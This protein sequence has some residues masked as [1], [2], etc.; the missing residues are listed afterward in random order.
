MS[1]EAPKNE[2][3]KIQSLRS[4]LNSEQ[5][6]NEIVKALPEICT[7]DRFMRVL[8]TTLTKNPKL[9]ECDRNSLL[10]ALLDC[11]QLGIEPDGRRAHLIPYGQNIQLIIDYKGLVELAMRSGKISNIHA[12]EVCENDEFV[13]NKGKI[14]K[15]IPNWKDRG[16]PYLVYAN[17]IFKDGCE[18][19]EVMTLE[20][21]NKVKAC[22][23]SANSTSSPWNTFPSEMR[24]KTVFRRLSKWLPLS[25]EDMNIIEKTEKLEYDFDMP[26][27]KK[28]IKVPLNLEPEKASFEPE[29]TN[30]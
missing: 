5:V 27:E 19:A 1:T 26:K 7:P 8:L 23:K 25:P 24:K 15:H 14:E 29:V 30:E 12:D 10:C 18:K 9:A 2:V 21:V 13:F 28:S 20:E 3:T 6:K 17:A 4:Y 16:K 11:S 22:S